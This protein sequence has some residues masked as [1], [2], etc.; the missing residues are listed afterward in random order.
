MTGTDPAFC[1]GLDLRDLG[2][3]KLRDL[4][5]FTGDAVVGADHRRR[6][7]PADVGETRSCSSTGRH[8]VQHR[9]R[10]RAPLKRPSANGIA[11][12]VGLDD[13]DV[14]AGQPCGEGRE[15]VAVE[16]DRRRR[17]HDGAQ[18]VGRQTRSRAD[19]AAR[20]SPRSAPDRDAPKRERHARAPER[21]RPR[22]AH[23]CREVHLVHGTDLASHRT[24]VIARAHRQLTARFAASTRAGTSE[25]RQ[26][27]LAISSAL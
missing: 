14:R 26:K 4:P 19:L 11:V 6:H 24:D 13:V 1:A 23:E 18:Q 7:G 27:R 21:R 16:L 17:R 8:V 9:E 25:S 20:R 2:V 3:P 10:D 15:H 12:R 5:S 22:L